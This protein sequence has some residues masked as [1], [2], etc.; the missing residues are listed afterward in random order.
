MRDKKEA[1]VLY[2]KLRKS[3]PKRKKKRFNQFEAQKFFRFGNSWRRL[4]H[5]GSKVA[6]LFD[7][8]KELVIG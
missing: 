8:R 5:T 6:I 3:L 2:L 1:M 4:S 7:D